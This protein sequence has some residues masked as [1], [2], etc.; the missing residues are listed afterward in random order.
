LE[1]S[2]G[3]NLIHST[4]NINP[5]KDKMLDTLSKNLE[6]LPVR[7]LSIS[8][9]RK[10]SNISRITN[11]G[12]L[13][14]FNLELIRITTIINHSHHLEKKNPIYK[15]KFQDWDN[16][17]HEAYWWNRRITKLQKRMSTVDLLKL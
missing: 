9:S 17:H 12:N 13:G 7:Q 4:R 8:I 16:E 10:N 3:S 15:M 14:L 1:E 5:F 2:K 6:A 11:K